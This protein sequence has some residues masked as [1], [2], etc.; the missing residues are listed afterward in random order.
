MNNKGEWLKERKNY[1][2]GSDIGALV[3]ACKHR[4]PLTVYNID[5]H[6]LYGMSIQK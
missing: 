3:G 6:N 4:T 1:L 2:G 5:Y